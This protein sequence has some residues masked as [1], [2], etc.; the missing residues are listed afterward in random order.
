MRVLSAA[1]IAALSAPEVRFVQL[2][3]MGFATPIGLSTSNM[4]FDYGGITYVGAAGLGTLSQVD[5]SP[6]E[7]KGMQFELAGVRSEYISLALD[8]AAVVQGT[9]VTIRTALLD[10]NCQIVDAPIDWTGTLDTMTITEDGETCT[11]QVTAESSAVDLL[12]GFALTY[13]DSDQRALHPGD[14]AFQYVAS[15]ANTPVVWPT[16]QWFIAASGR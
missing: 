7:I 13:S 1:A 3:L 2:V 12:R 15:Q 10:A 6:G 14:L 8:D 9:P 11:I 5:D 16:K 4:D